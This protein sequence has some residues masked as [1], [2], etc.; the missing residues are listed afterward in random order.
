MNLF[1]SARS[2]AQKKMNQEGYVLSLRRGDPEEGPINISQNLR[3]L[4]SAYY[5]RRNS[6]KCLQDD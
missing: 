6:R 1:P 5:R 3:K 4:L 2:L